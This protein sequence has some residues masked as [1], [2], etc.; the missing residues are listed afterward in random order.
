MKWNHVV[1][2]ESLLYISAVSVHY[3]FPFTSTPT[4]SHLGTGAAQQPEIVKIMKTT[5]LMQAV[6]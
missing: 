6:P 4:T 3:L 5:H 1:S 2:A